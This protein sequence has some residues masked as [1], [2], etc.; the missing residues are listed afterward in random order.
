MD[1][2][3]F[4]VP[5]TD[6]RNAEGAQRAALVANEL[7]REIS[8]GHQLYQAAFSVI[9]DPWPNDDYV[10]RLDDGRV[11]IVHLTGRGVPE[12][13]PCPDTDFV[14]DEAALRAEI[15]ARY[16]APEEFEDGD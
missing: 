11:V 8:P 7:R 9:A 6:L 13:P 1:A 5:V 12:P 2:F 14:E 10:V 15:L 4:D 16:G 3:V